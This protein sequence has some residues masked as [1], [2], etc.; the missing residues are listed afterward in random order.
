MS[1]EHRPPVSQLQSAA[2]VATL[3][4]PGSNMETAAGAWRQ[5]P[6]STVDLDTVGRAQG[7]DPEAEL[8]DPWAGGGGLLP[9][10]GRGRPISERYVPE[11]LIARGAMGEV[12][13][14][15]DLRLQTTSALKV[16]LPEVALRTGARERFL[17]EINVTARLN[18]PGILSV[19]DQGELPD[20]RLWYT[21]DE[22][23]GDTLAHAILA[24]H[25]AAAEGPGTPTDWTARRL[26]T[27]FHQLCLA[28]AAAH[29]EQ[30]VHRDLKPDN[31]MVGRFGEVRV[32]DWGLARLLDQ[33]EA[34]LDPELPLVAGHGRRTLAGHVLGTPVYMAPEQAA[35]RVEAVCPA[36]DVY[37]LGVI[38]FEIITGAPPWS[39]APT[40]A[41]R[42]H[43][44]APEQL[45]KGAPVELCAICTRAMRWAPADRF[46][47][48]GA[49][50]EEVGIYLDGARRR[51][52]ALAVFG[53]AA[54]AHPR[55]RVML[56]QA[57]DRAQ[58]ARRA[59]QA[60]PLDAGPDEKAPIWREQDLAAKER[61]EA[62]RLEWEA[63]QS[64]RGA[65]NLAP[66]LPE[67]HQLLADHYANRLIEAE[68]GGRAEEVEELEEQ[69]KVHDRGQHWPLIRGQGR[70]S[71]QTDPPGAIVRA[72]RF[73]EVGRRLRPVDMGV[74]GQTPLVEE[75]LP[76]GS[77]LLEVTA[78]GRSAV[79]IAVRL[80]RLEHEAW[81]DP[82]TGSPAVHR[83]PRLG[84][85]PPGA[86]LVPAGWF[87][88]GGD[89]LAI[90]ATDEARLWLDAFVVQ[91]TPL[92][93]E[94]WL[95]FLC[96]ERAAGRPL[97]GLLPATS[98]VGAWRL[99]VAGEPLLDPAALGMPVMCPSLAAA[100]AYAAHATAQTG[101]PWRL[102][103]D[104]EWE[105]AARGVD[106]RQYPWGDHFEPSWC[107]MS[108][109]GG[110]QPAVRPVRENTWDIGPF[111]MIGAA[112]NVREACRNR[113]RRQSLPDGA[114]VDV[115]G[116]DAGPDDR[117]MMV[118]G[119]SAMS[120][121]FHCR[122]AG[123]FICRPAE[124][125]VGLGLRLAAGFGGGPA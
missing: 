81:I 26:A 68:A 89:P 59:L 103:H 1:N 24:H 67:A 22:V 49:M 63:V 7:D 16:M 33:P 10:G 124:P 56:G 37:A 97:D 29:E 118:R 44:P 69:L 52:E 3:A 9:V 18:H 6:A 30:V 86:L 122:L 66:E 82:R 98:P 40:A 55:A 94:D 78:P 80:G 57:A 88:S 32:M 107:Q 104:L 19:H 28:V 62:R 27:V 5:S 83:L 12:Y 21:M 96:A 106:G 117:Y 105:K 4:L 120:M 60:L 102:P 50:A 113:Y 111:G 91:E 39:R 125:M 58:A 79:R 17:R 70:I 23:R 108:Q 15:W 43:P 109:T 85:L 71:L 92:T 14:V 84:A 64:A 38:L 101:L 74:I 36:S 2:A 77:Y 41:Q 100:Q 53:A 115:L 48:A 13:R 47:D 42:E 112:G 51:A 34:G 72:A 110:G 54:A 76:R 75:G 25:L 46:A 93:Q 123:R 99:G 20:R 87:R 116:D 121:A 8:S 95:R 31:V 90:D 35:G 73:E 65:L 114:A 11:R 45:Q 119:G 61:R